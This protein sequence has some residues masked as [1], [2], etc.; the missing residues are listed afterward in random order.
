[1]AGTMSVASVVAMVVCCTPALHAG[2]PSSCTPGTSGV[3]TCAAKEVKMPKPG[4]LMRIAGDMD[5][6]IEE[7]P[8]NTQEG[9]KTIS[10]NMYRMGD[11]RITTPLPEGYPAPTPPK[12]IDIKGYPLVR[13]AQVSGEAN[14]DIG[15][16][17]GF[18]PLFNHIKNRDIAMTSPVEMEYGSSEAKTE[19]KEQSSGSDATDAAKRQWTMAFLY[20]TTDMGQTGTA[21]DNKKVE[22][23]DV[24][25]MT[26]MAMGFKGIYSRGMFDMTVKQLRA[27]LAKLPEWEAEGEP[28]ALYYNGPEVPNGRKW[29]EVQIPIKRQNMQAN[30]IDAKGDSTDVKM[31]PVKIEKP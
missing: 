8:T 2:E 24:P 15:M 17:V 22:V 16:N 1:M 21:D 31:V 10:F 20:R 26:V 18:W 4:E 27:E 7:I 5:V 23:V 13:R 29:G 3:T 30:E 28:R 9:G 25:P 14:P 11:M 12:A 19:S 6:K